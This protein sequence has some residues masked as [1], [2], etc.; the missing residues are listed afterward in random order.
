MSLLPTCKEVSE[1]TARE[2]RAGLLVALHFLY[3]AGC[4]RFRAQLA[5]VAAALKEKAFPRPD[6]ARVAALE[7][8]VLSKLKP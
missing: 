2:D 8:A 5:L 1:T 7:K 3:C 6:A 4:R